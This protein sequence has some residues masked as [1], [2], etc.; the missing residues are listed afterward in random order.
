MDIDSASVQSWNSRMLSPRN[1]HIVGVTA[2]DINFVTQTVNLPAQT[3]LCVYVR[4]FLL[5]SF[6]D[7]D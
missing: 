3:R 6:A 5:S 7:L 1:L 2:G 4:F